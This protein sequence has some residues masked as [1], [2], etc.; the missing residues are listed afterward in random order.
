MSDDIYKDEMAMARE[1]R[2]HV[3]KSDRFKTGA[4]S[5]A[6]QCPR[7][8]R[9]GCDRAGDCVRYCAD[10]RGTIRELQ[11]GIGALAEESAER[12]TRVSV[13]EHSLADAHAKREQLR[14][15]VRTLYFDLLKIIAEDGAPVNHP[16]RAVAE[17]LAAVIDVTA[18][19]I[20]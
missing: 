9:F 2:E 18:P 16:M 12:L 8:E 6:S 11:E 15:G 19:E 10:W 1:R 17:R 5:R 14:V 4:E 20:T 7:C 13:L 3:E